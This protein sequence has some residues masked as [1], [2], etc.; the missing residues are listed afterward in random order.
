LENSYRRFAI[1]RIVPALNPA[2]DRQPFPTPAKVRGATEKVDLAAFR[3]RKDG[4]TGDLQQA[5]TDFFGLLA[6]LLVEELVNGVDAPNQPDNH[7][8][9]PNFLSLLYHLFYSRDFRAGASGKNIFGSNY[10]TNGLGPAWDVV[11]NVLLGVAAPNPQTLA[12]PIRKLCDKLNEDFER[13][14]WV[15]AW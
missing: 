9:N 11:L 10:Q 15:F 5:L 7:A 8:Q 12:A 6:P 1:D 13:D 3:R 2:P 14:I 4:N